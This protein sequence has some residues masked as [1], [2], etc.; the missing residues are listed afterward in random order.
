M[1]YEAQPNFYLA[2]DGGW[3]PLQWDGWSWLP[4]AV[5]V[6]GDGKVTAGQG[7]G[8]RRSPHRTGSCRT[9]GPG[10]D[11]LAP[12]HRAPTG[13]PDQLAYQYGQVAA[14]WW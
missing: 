2:W 4:S 10:G 3:L 7:H 11:E 6:A 13:S 9:G 8:W 14:V 5:H 1:R 12:A